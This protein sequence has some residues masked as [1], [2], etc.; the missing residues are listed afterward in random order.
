[1]SR[2]R[3]DE[4]LDSIVK[5]IKENPDQNVAGIGSKL[6]LDNK[7]VQRALL[8]LEDRGELLQEDNQGRLR[9]F[10]RRV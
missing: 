8:Q 4:R 5:C 1:M 3:N 2:K 6:D 7:I 10:K 9:W